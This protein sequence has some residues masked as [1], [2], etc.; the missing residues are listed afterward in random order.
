MRVLVTGSEGY[1]GSVLVPYLV[2]V[3]HEV[4]GLDTGFFA[5]CVVG[6]TP[7]SGSSSHRT[8]AMSRPTR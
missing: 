2:H 6:A 5:E 1:I 8:F 4:V 3:G 7:T